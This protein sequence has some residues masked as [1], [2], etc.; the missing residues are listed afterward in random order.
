MNATTNN[1]NATASTPAAPVATD[2][3]DGVDTNAFRPYDSQL[4]IPELAGFRTVKCLYKIA[5][6]GKNAGKA[7]G[8]NSYIRI[9]DGITETVV[10]ERIAELAPYLTSYLQEQENLLVKNLHKAGMTV[11]SPKQYGLDAV[12]A[13]LEEA[14]TASRMNKEMIETWFD[15]DLSDTLLVA[16]AEKMGLDENMTAEDEEKLQTIVA[17]Y[18]AKLGSLASPKVFYKEEEVE[19]LLKAIGFAEGDSPVKPRIVARLEKMKDSGTTESL[20]SLL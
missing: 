2:I 3:Q 8:E 18:K 16:F 9:A 6:T 1:L 14:G 15:A 4:P 17:V 13:M 20:M 11:V 5:K 7:A 12:I 19:M 10:A